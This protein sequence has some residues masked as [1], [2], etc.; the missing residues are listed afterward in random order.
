MNVWLR[1]IIQL[2]VIGVVVLGGVMSVAH[3]ARELPTV[4]V[5][6]DDTF[7][8][9]GLAKNE[10]NFM[11]ILAAKAHGNQ[12]FSSKIVDL[13]RAGET[14]DSVVSRVNEILS[15]RPAIVVLGVGLNDAVNQIEPDVVFGNLESVLNALYNSQVNVLLL[16]IKAPS[17][18]PDDYELRFNRIYADLASRY[19]VYLIPNLMDGI[20]F[21]PRYS[22]N[23]GILPSAKGVEKMFD[24][25]TPVYVSMLRDFKGLAD[26]CRRN[27]ENPS[28]SLIAP[29]AVLPAAQ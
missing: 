17:S 14:A 18:L 23:D 16:G 10:Q 12:N 19:Q 6:G 9:T 29:Q 28:C 4:V 13:S 8:G 25:F 21:D 26:L 15:Y 27:P 22:Q 3:A 11:Q 20:F 7:I 24:S 2:S 1:K 5:V